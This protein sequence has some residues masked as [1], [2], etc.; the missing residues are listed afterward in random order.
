MNLFPF[1]ITQRNYRIDGL[2][3]VGLAHLDNRWAG[4]TGSEKFNQLLDI[5]YYLFIYLFK[6]LQK[7]TSSKILQN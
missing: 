7:Y 2:E 3:R 1:T 5:F 6:N 4:P